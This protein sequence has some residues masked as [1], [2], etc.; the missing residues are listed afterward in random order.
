MW[1]LQNG[2]NIL[3]PQFEEIVRYLHGAGV[4][5]SIASNGHSIMTMADDVLAMFNDLEVSINYPSAEQQDRLRGPGNWALVHQ[6]IQQA[7]AH[8]KNISILATLM[9]QPGRI[10]SRSQLTEAIHGVSFESYDRA[11]N[12][13]I[14][15][16]RRKLEPGEYII[17]IHGVGYKFAGE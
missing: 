6:A 11:I 10:F 4:K 13:H 7:H 8:G 2:E 5:L 14:N 16:L 9:S 1:G 15:N 3:H 12:S 17:T